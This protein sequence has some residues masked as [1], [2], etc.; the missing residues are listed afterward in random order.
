M[1][2]TPKSLDGL[3]LLAKQTVADSIDDRL[4]KLAA[5]VAFYVLLSGPPLLLTT[6]GSV[7]AVARTIG[8]EAV[9]TLR[10]NLD[11]VASALFD[12]RALELTRSLIDRFLTTEAGTV[13]SIGAVTALWTASRAMDAFLDAVRVAYDHDERSSGFRQRLVSLGFTTGIVIAM[14]VLVPLLIAGPDLARTIGSVLRLGDQFEALVHLIYWPSIALAGLGVLVTLYHFAPGRHTQWRRDIPGAVLALVGWIG[15]AAALRV[16]AA[17]SFG[18]E[19]LY[20]PLAAPLILMLFVWWTA[21]ALLL[22]A[23]LNSEIDKLWPEE[24]KP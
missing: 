14:V 18:S 23:E 10:G 8:P 17:F 22:G 21:I 19:S 24:S 1:S 6:L 13:I 12:A 7:G 11:T 3:R 2:P 5:E 15:S 20:G 9:A 16:Y 4:P